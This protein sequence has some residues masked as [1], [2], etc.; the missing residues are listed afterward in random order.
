MTEEILEK[1]EDRRKYKT[2]NQKI[3]RLLD[4]DIKRVCSNTKERWLKEK[5]EQAEQLEGRDTREMHKII[6]EIT[7]KRERT[8]VN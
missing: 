1:M 6:R 2:V 4:K 7:G 8:E 5:Y 3:Y